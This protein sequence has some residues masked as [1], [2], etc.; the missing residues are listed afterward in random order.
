MGSTSQLLSALPE[1]GVFDPVAVARAL[2]PL[3]AAHAAEC[4]ATRRVPDTV[5]AALRA[6][7]LFHMTAPRR[8]GGP[9]AT[10]I[11]HIETI[12]ELAKGCVSTA[13]AFG[14]LSGVTGTALGMRPEVTALLFRTGDE[15][16]CSASSMTG[17]A[18][19]VE[20]G[21]RV[22][23]KWGYGSG[24]LH[25]AWALNG[26]LV[27]DAESGAVRPAMAFIDLAAPATRIED[28]WH[29]AGMAG[30]GSNLIHAEDLFVPA[31]LIVYPDMV[32]PHAV[33]A[34]MPGIEPRD[35]WPFESLFPL[36][37]LSPMLGAASAILEAVVAGAASRPVV[38]WTYPKQAASEALV[39]EIGRAALDIDSAWMHIRRAAATMDET[40]PQRALTGFEKARI[41][42]DCG[43]AMRLLREA[44]NRLMDVAGPGAFALANPLQRLW[45]D[46]NVGTRHN[47][48][49]AGL[50]TELY[51]RAILGLPSN[52]HLLPDVSPVPDWAAV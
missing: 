32:P 19:P 14:L 7:G 16:F 21:Y 20:G 34:A 4:E 45:R 24:C 23:G 5:M 6:S 43:H 38:G 37:V 17:T 10:M 12:A 51:G 9:G 3:L 30:S 35:F 26:V 28:N 41:Q 36:G 52:I 8:A 2:R 49:N 13:W 46:L 11:A 27:R 25:A 33:L 44:G 47:A 22:A 42:A 1:P 29:M 39:G 48:L 15:L 18:E 31:A 40:A 50:S